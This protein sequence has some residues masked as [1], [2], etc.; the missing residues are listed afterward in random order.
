MPM[1]QSWNPQNKRWVKY[2]LYSGK[3]KTKGMKKTKYVGIKVKG[4]GK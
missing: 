3:F 4:K 1:Y 2:T